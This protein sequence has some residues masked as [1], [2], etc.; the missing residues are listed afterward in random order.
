MGK[1]WYSQHHRLHPVRVLLGSDTVIDHRSKE[2]MTGGSTECIVPDL[3]VHTV[4]VAKVGAECEAFKWEN[5]PELQQARQAG[6]QHYVQIKVEPP[7]VIDGKVAEEIILL[8]LER[9]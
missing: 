5:T 1:R 3:P 8:D 9:K 4:M 7:V 2:R 6:R